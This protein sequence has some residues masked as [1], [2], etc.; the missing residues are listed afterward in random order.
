MPRDTGDGG[1]SPLVDKSGNIVGQEN[2]YAAHYL[3]T[4]TGGIIWNWS[5]S[6]DKTSSM[7]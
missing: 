3:K 5:P 1:K 2:E 6:E 7:K 4:R